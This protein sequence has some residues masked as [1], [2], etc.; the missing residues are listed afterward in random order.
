MCDAVR[1]KRSGKK[2][3]NGRAKQ[4]V[5]FA[6]GAQKLDCGMGR[7]EEGACTQV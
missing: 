5:L 7:N 1:K 2:K 6:A 4:K 3:K